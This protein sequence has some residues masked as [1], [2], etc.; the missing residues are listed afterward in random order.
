MLRSIE[1]TNPILGTVAFALSV[2]VSNRV[3]AQETPAPDCVQSFEN[4]QTLRKAGKLLASSEALIACSQPSCPA[5]IAKE[6]TELYT[7]AQNSLPS[8]TVGA[9]DSQGNALTDISVYL[10]GKLLTEHP[11]GRAVQVD[12]GVHELK[13]MPKDKPE[14]IMKALVAEGEKN[15]LVSAVIPTPEVKSTQKPEPVTEP[16]QSSAATTEKHSSP[17]IAAYIVGGLGVLAVGTGV[18]LRLLASHDYDHLSN[19]C[20]SS[21][22]D[23]DVDSLSRKYTVSSI[24]LAGGGAALAT[25]GVLFFIHGSSKSQPQSGFVLAPTPVGAGAWA[26]WRGSF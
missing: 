17:P 10:D 19:T 20:H 21:C 3:W 7:Q 16:P 1:K 22:S 14:V 11:D 26:S 4:G 2:F 24:V 25:A 23:S 13:F 15:K 5:F 12:P 18:T 6:C 9:V 8:I